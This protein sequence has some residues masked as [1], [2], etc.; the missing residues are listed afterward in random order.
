MAEAETGEDGLRL[1][2]ELKPELVVIEFPVPVPGYDSLTEALRAEPGLEGLVILTVTAL[3]LP[4]YR[5]RALRAGVDGFLTK[6]I[7][8]RRLLREVER[9]LRAEEPSA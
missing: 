5:A 6:P 7:E 2:R 4:A 1:A 3:A 8:P 9:H